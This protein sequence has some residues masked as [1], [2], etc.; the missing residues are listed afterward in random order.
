MQTNK[1][2]VNS[3]VV[4]SIILIFSLSSVFAEAYIL[5]SHWQTFGEQSHVKA[6]RTKGMMC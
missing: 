3:Q 4:D 5:S 1:N 2:T 6:L